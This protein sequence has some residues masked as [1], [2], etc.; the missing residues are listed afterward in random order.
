M[1]K[2]KRIKCK[3]DLKSIKKLLPFPYNTEADSSDLEVIFAGVSEKK[4]LLNK[5][6]WGLKF[7]GNDTFRGFSNKYGPM[8]P[9]GLIVVFVEE[10]D[11]TDS[12]RWILCHELTHYEVGYSPSLYR[13]FK[14]LHSKY[15]KE[16]ENKLNKK[17]CTKIYLKDNIHD[18]EPEEIL[19]DQVATAI[20]GENYGRK[21][22]RKQLRKQKCGN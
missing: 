20:V 16:V 14:N 7:I 22:W 15:I 4:R 5:H 2:L 11:T 12:L 10:F 17:W 13:A 19:C 6:A 3:I 1:I 8:N 9:M 18:N 21:W